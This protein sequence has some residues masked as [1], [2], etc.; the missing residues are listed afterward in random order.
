M[1]DQP[2]LLGLSAREQTLTLGFGPLEVTSI[3]LALRTRHRIVS[4]GLSIPHSTL[5][6][7]RSGL[8]GVLGIPVKLLSVG[9]G[10]V[11]QLV[12]LDFSIVA[13]NSGVVPDLVSLLSG[14][15][16]DFPGLGSDFGGSLSEE[17][18]EKRRAGDVSRVALDD[19]TR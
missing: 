14:F 16:G 13:E 3:R 17:E 10:I 7:T 19:C 12:G 9:F 15:F 5:S 4:L 11:G 1:T 2:L 8:S 18:R 6:F